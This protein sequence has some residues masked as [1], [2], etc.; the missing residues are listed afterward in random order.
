[1]HDAIAAHHRP[2]GP[3]RRTASRLWLAWITAI[4]FAPAAGGL[5]RAQ[6]PPI[7]QPSACSVFARTGT[8]PTEFCQVRDAAIGGGKEVTVSLTA[9]T[10]PVEVGGYRV[11]TE[12]YNGKYLAPTIELDPGDRLNVRLS[13][14]LSPRDVLTPSGVSGQAMDPTMNMG[15]AE[16]ADPTN[17]HTH[18]LIVSP[19]NAND[20]ERGNGDNVFVSLSRGDWLDYS[21]GIP[22][23]LPAS[24]L[25]GPAGGRIPHPSGLYWYHSHLHGISAGQVAGGMSGLISIGRADSN[26]VVAGN[27]AADQAN[28][29]AAQRS[30]T[31][32]FYL[33][34]RDLQVTTAHPPADDPA[35]IASATWSTDSRDNP[36]YPN[37]KAVPLPAPDKREGYCQSPLDPSKVWLF[38]VNGQ[39]FPQITIGAGRG[40][41]LRIG[42]L[43]PNLTYRLRLLPKGGG[44]PL[45][46]SLLSVDG[47]VPGK[48][49]PITGPAGAPKLAKS[50]QLSELSLMP[51]SRAE[52]YVQGGV[53]TY[54]LQTC[55]QHTGTAQVLESCAPPDTTGVTEGDHWPEIQ[56]AQLVFAGTKL[57]ELALNASPTT[58]G[59]QPPAIA[60]GLAPSTPRPGCL[61]DIDKGA[62][63]FRRVTFGGSGNRFSMNVE[64]LAPPDAT[65]PFALNKFKSVPGASSGFKAFD[66]YLKDGTVD[67]DAT[68][69]GPKHTCVKLSNG[70]GQLW[71]LKNPTQELHNFHIHQMKFRLATDADLEAYGLD[72]K[73][74][75]APLPASLLASI[76]DE[77]RPD[78]ATWH[79]TIPVP[80]ATGQVFVI[81]NF[82]AQEQV[83]RFVFH[84]HILKHEDGG[85]MAPM[86]VIQ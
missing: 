56:L 35:T 45:S 22:K 61:P 39:R 38:T 24:I 67:W 76:E 63:Q 3:A 31:D 44:V 28:K 42:N 10:S 46:F 86:E 40:A 68:G 6:S 12:N 37:D 71:E 23:D 53:G 13:N 69:G 55:E 21:I 4:V 34:L 82:D 26:V 77:D 5:A 7:V 70:H 64:I 50:L 47:V 1:M 36:C 30:V 65:H 60:A 51:A 74:V 73:T 49:T 29:T 41:L 54:L 2:R 43:S 15:G 58:Q 33:V 20:P 84:C 11:V 19:N 25:D 78:I 52:I 27:D 18:G 16:G 17:L 72:P 62:H 75:P 66:A 14:A 59:P 79:D 81:M 83:G 80:A 32:V 57:Q 85:L 9:T 8:R 48:P